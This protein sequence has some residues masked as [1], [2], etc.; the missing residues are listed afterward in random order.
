ME[1]TQ[2][3]VDPLDDG[4]V[5]LRLNRPEVR[6]A[7]S[8][9]LR[10]EVS[11]AVEMFSANPAT[12]AFVITGV[13][14]TFCA[15]FDLSEFTAAADDPDLNTVLWASS[16]RFHHSLMR[17]PVPVI[18]ALNGPALAGGFDL[19]TL[20]D[21]R[22]AGPTAWFARPEV[23]WAVPLYR[24]LHD[25]VGGGI[26]RELC[27]TSRRVELEEALRIGLVNSV[28]DDPLASALELASAIAKRPSVAVRATKAKFIGVAGV[29]ARDT[30]GL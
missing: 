20:C 24:P 2:L 13:G 19:A 6:N 12:A 8:I 18:A 10:D 9:R 11:H 28:A 14:P 3:D 30:L 29:A 15:G 16:D 7:L 5:V 21:V 26:A 22:I 1:F 4:V 23:E 27:L 17:C 25:I